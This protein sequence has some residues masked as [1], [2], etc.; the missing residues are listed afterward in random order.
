[1]SVLN[2][3]K[4]AAVKAVAHSETP[5]IS[6]WAGI[7]GI[8]KKKLKRAALEYKIERVVDRRIR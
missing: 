2:R 4:L 8:P 6:Y 7:S 5:N 3:D 1:M